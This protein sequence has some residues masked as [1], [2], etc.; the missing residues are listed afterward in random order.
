MRPIVLSIGLL[1]GVGSA[2]FG[3]SIGSEG[4]G[5]QSGADETA[6][7]DLSL[8]MSAV[9]LIDGVGAKCNSCHTAGKTEIQ[10]WGAALTN[11]EN[12]CLSPSLTMTAA[13]R[14]D[15]LRDDPTDPTSTFSPDK[16]G[17]YAAGAS[18]QQFSDLFQQAF[19]ADQW[20]A[21]FANFK[22]QA[23]MPAG[24]RPGFT[25][26]QFST[27]KSWVL[28]GMPK[29]DDVMET[30]GAF[31]CNPSST[32]ELEAHLAQM[33]TDGWGA[34]LA[35]ASTPMANCGAATTA[36]ACL[37][38]LPDLTPTWG[39]AGTPQMMR[40]V[41]SLGFRSSWW[42]RSS[43]DGKYSAFGGSPSKII[44]TEN[45]ANDVTVDAPYDPGFFPNNDGFSF[46]SAGNGGGIRVCKQSV[47]TSAIAGSHHITFNEPGC[48]E[49]IDTVYE[50][51]GA[52]L[53]GSLFF[54]ATGVHTNDSGSGSGP[55]SADFGSGATTTLS[56]MFNNGTA[57]VH[58][59]DISVPVPNEG[60]QQMSPSNTL[61]ITRFGST[62]S[63]AGYHI[64]TVTPTITPPT[65][66]GGV[67]S[68]SVQTKTIGTICIAGGKPQMSFDERFIA[69]HQYVDQNANPQGLPTNSSNIFVVDL[70]T[71]NTVQVT[72]MGAGQ[73]ALY[74]HFRADGW[75]IFVV[76]DSVANKETLVASDVVLRMQ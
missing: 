59:T 56:P 15:C 8:A 17:L 6:T 28:K 76:R 14:V 69:V 44:D 72:K 42:V 71:G 36:S 68:V 54:M 25:A 13:Q 41:R 31:P 53:D 46:A 57:Y 32:P 22:N 49:I 39:F 51:I 75:L 30:A 29:L 16:L 37:T 62:S 20:Q 48:T 21:Q 52:S 74:P 34:R 73:R 50:S 63:T 35:A 65:T 5:S 12:G 1:V 26:D 24:N 18:L 19:P 10:R 7:D 40:N 4:V 64:R 33:K 70:K 47:L 60:D 43:A 66:A 9:K 2:A 38:N 11:I 45:P 58:G 3:C 23:A 61:L 55:I 67:A 27:I